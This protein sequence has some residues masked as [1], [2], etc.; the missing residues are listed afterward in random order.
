MGEVGLPWRA[1]PNLEPI[2]RGLGHPSCRVCA[3]PFRC[4]PDFWAGDPQILAKVALKNGIPEV[5]SQGA[6]PEPVVQ[7]VG[8][9]A[10]M[11]A[12]QVWDKVS[13]LLGSRLGPYPLGDKVNGAAFFS[14]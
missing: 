9:V 10:T 2:N 7:V 8:V 5:G 12:A 3:K 4:K 6:V 13:S 11:L 1:L 14:V